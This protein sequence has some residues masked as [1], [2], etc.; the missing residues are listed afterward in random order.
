MAVPQ[1]ADVVIIAVLAFGGTQSF[2]L[3]V[4]K[5]KSWIWEQFGLVTYV[6]KQ[7]K[8]PFAARIMAAIVVGTLIYLA[9]RQ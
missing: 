7:R 9:L 3:Q 6:Q 4:Y 2:T 8:M 1:S 5:G